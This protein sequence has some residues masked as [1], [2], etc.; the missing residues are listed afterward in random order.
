MSHNLL[1]ILDWF[2]ANQLSI[3]LD[4]TVMMYFWPD[5]NSIKV[6][7]GDYELPV[8]P[9]TK[10][11]VFLDGRM[12]WKYHAE[13]LHNK[14]SMNKQLLMTSKNKLDWDSL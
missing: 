10:F 7:V 1:I 8:V 12:S 9:F 4:K 3:N 14:L 2:K 5:C 13:H 6:K 11:L